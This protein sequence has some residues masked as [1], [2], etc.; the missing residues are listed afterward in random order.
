MPESEPHVV[1]VIGDAIGGGASPAVFAQATED[2]DAIVYLGDCYLA[3]RAEEW[4]KLDRDYPAWVKPLMRPTPGNHDWPHRAEGYDPYFAS[5][6]L[7]NDAHH[8]SF[9]VGAWKF[10]AFNSMAAGDPD[11]GQAQLDFVDAELDEPGT[12]KIVYCH[13]APYSSDTAHGDN[14][15]VQPVLG[16]MEGRAIL[17]M[18]GHSHGMEEFAP[19]NGV[20]TIV[21]GAGG[22][23]LY[24]FDPR[25]ETAWFDNSHFG[26]CRLTLHDDGALI[27]DWLDQHG[28]LLRTTRL[29]AQPAA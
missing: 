28:T 23:A 29:Q 13:H 17:H 8:Y 4:A 11:P 18:A 10:I 6:G 25:P 3:G 20:T 19:R 1:F 26:L 16:L 14:P 21:Q 5:L 27:V 9:R 22:R 7:P 2:A 12:M 24:T 15:T